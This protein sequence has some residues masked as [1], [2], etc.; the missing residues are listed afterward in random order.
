MAYVQL[1]RPGAPV[2]FGSFASSMSMQSG[3]PTFG[4]PEPAL[5]LYT[6]AA[7][8][9]RLGRAVPLAAVR[10][11]RRRSPTP[12]PRTS[13]PTRCSPRAGRRELRPARG[14]WLEGGLTMGYEKFVLDRTRRHVAAFAKGVDLSRTA[15]PWTRSSRT[16]RASTSWARRTRW[17]TSRRR[18]TGRPIADNNSL[19]AVGDRGIGRRG[20]RANTIWK[21]TLA[22]YEPPPIDEAMDEELREWIERGRPFPDSNT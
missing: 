21:R 22:E 17:P 7:C 3:A 20:Q 18:S 8:A 5:V 4:T 12:R 16:G 10:S 1:V 11:P 14:G 9:R 2:V 13:R 6:L 15:R 19:R